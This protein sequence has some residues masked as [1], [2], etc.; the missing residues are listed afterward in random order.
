M[1]LVLVVT[2]K[3]TSDD[4]VAGIELGAAQF[5]CLLDLFRVQVVSHGCTPTR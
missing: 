1:L 4:A 3:T 2:D 5:A